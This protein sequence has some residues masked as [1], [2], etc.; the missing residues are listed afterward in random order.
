MRRRAVD[1][2][3][4]ANSPDAYGRPFPTSCGTPSSGYDYGKKLYFNDWA[5]GWQAGHIGDCIGF[6]VNSWTPT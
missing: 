1:L 4:L 6:V 5:S 2:G 3:T